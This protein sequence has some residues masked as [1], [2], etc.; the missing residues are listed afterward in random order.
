MP[1]KIED[2]DLERNDCLQCPPKESRSSRSPEPTEPPKPPGLP[3]DQ[4]EEEDGDQRPEAA[5]KVKP[6][7]PPEDLRSPGICDWILMTAHK[8]LGLPEDE[9]IATIQMSALALPEQVP[10]TFVCTKKTCK[11]KCVH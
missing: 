4:K 5:K 6:T 7:S 1:V 10:R 11:P 8:R 2:S 9:D 3:G